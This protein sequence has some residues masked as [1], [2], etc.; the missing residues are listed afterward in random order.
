VVFDLHPVAQNPRYA[1]KALTD[2]ATPDI[3]DAY[4]D[5]VEQV[6]EWLS[7]Y[8]PGRVALEPMNE[9][10]LT[11]RSGDARWRG[12]LEKLCSRVLARAPRLA[13]V[14]NGVDWDGD[15]ALERLDAAPFAGD[16]AL[17]TFHYYQPH[18]FTLQGVENDT[19][20]FISGLGWP[21]DRA[22]AARALEAAGAAIAEA[23][24]PL[25]KGDWFRM[26]TRQLLDAYETEARA[27]RI[28]ED[29]D[30]LAR[31]AGARGIARERILLGE[32]GCVIS[33]RGVPLGDDR[34]RWL[35]AVRAAAETAGFAWAY[36]SYKG[37]G[38]MEL[39]D[40][41][42]ALHTDVLASLGLTAP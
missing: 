25:G 3:F 42:G 4:L 30:R 41:A 36:W 1:P 11:G 20:R 27:T 13:L 9:P 6:A 23:E 40:A 17:H 15:A 37:Y 24:L 32:F 19:T 18:T 7:R 8:P 10:L 2:P 35:R 29:F 22:N 26:R 38:G 31:W 33:S 12:M 34:L 39:V 16:G 14:V 21:F 5:V 28:G